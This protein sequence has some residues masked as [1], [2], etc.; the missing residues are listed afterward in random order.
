[1]AKL[2]F[3]RGDTV[4][5]L[6]GSNE[7]V[8]S[9]LRWS[10]AMRGVIVQVKDSQYTVRY[11]SITRI[12][13]YVLTEKERA[14][15]EAIASVCRG[16]IESVTVRALKMVGRTVSGTTLHGLD[17]RGLV[18]SHSKIEG[19]GPRAWTLTEAGKRALA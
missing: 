13:T 6:R 10:D 12:E 9:I 1:M 18:T 8:G 5:F 17:Q 2:I 14:G 19:S 4:R 15:L 7:Y 3:R 11:D 16:G